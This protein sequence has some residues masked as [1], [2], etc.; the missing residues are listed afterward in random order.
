MY[1]KLKTVDVWISPIFVNLLFPGKFLKL[2]QLEWCMQKSGNLKFC[3]P[4]SRDIQKA[5][6]R[7]D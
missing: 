1:P 5:G 7:E 4:S 3:V 2:N 6:K